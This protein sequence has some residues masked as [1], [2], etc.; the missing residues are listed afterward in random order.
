MRQFFSIIMA[1]FNP[2]GFISLDVIQLKL[3]M[4]SLAGAQNDKK[5]W[6]ALVPKKKSDKFKM[7][8]LKLKGAQ[9]LEFLRSVIPEKAIGNP[10]LCT[11]F[12]GSF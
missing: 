6:S 4:Q 3:I 11:F 5:K 9:M 12:D 8:L 10:T 1:Q 7:V 2:L